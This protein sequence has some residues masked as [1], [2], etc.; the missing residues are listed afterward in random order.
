MGDA[1][2]P[3]QLPACLL[4][5]GFLNR[6]PI[7]SKVTNSRSVVAFSR[8]GEGLEWSGHGP[9]L[10]R[11]SEQAGVRCAMAK[12]TVV[13]TTDGRKS[14]LLGSGSDRQ[15]AKVGARAVPSDGTSTSSE[16]LGG[17]MEVG[18]C[19][20]GQ[21]C[22]TSLAPGRVQTQGRARRRG[23][24]AYRLG[25]GCHSPKQTRPRL[26][27]LVTA[28]TRK[29]GSGRRVHR[30]V[31]RLALAMLL[32]RRDQHEKSVMRSMPQGPFVS[33]MAACRRVVVDGM[34]AR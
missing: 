15:V 3:V 9:S 29:A 33:S 5:G 10:A 8:Y 13:R 34:A 4:G 24:A 22:E 28:T 17:G 20:F 27:R 26:P 12:T 23:L 6:R 25:R 30:E 1:A 14:T 16:E 11:A 21:G 31:R 19:R 32:V 7:K 18:R 2:R